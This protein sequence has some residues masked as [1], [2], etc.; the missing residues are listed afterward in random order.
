MGCFWIRQRGLGLGMALAGL[1]FDL[2]SCLAEG[3]GSAGLCEGI[4]GSAG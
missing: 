4:G 1:G 3:L 2:I